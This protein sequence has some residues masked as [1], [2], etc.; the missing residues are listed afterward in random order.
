MMRFL[1]LALGF[2][3]ILAPL[4]AQKQKQITDDTIRDQVM[5]RLADDP[6]IGG[7]PIDVDVH[8]GVATLKGKVR[9]DKQKSKAEKVAKKVK[10]V[11]GVTNQLVISPD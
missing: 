7:M 6:E 11:T 2:M 8:E 5:V 9:N 3:L 4:M 10:G 1:C